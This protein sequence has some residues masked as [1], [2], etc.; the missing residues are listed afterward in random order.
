[1]MRRNSALLILILISTASLTWGQAAATNQPA[2]Q[3]GDAGITPNRVIGEVK[4][5]DKTA[6]QLVVKTDAGS[7]VTATLADTTQYMRVAPG[8]TSITNATKITFAELAEGDRVMAMGKV[9]EDKKT[10]PTRALVVMTKGDLAKKHEAERA[11]WR[12]RGI[13]GVV[14]ALNPTTKEITISSR[15]MGGMQSVIIPVSDKVELRRYAP[16]SIKF[17]DAKESSFAELQVGDQLRALGERAPD[18]TR[19]TPEKVVTGAF[20]TVVGT[21]T[22]VDAATGELKITEAE[23]KQALTIVVKQD[24]V[25]RRFPGEMGG[26]MMMSRPAGAGNAA[27]QPA[28][29]APQ[30]TS[31]GGGGPGGGPRRGGNFN[32][33]EMMESMPAIAIADLKPGEMI[34]V[35]STKGADPTRLTAIS[36]LS[37]AEPLLTMIAARQPQQAS[38]S[39]PNPAGGLGNSGIQFGIGLP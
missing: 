24:A 34:I 15:A 22:A 13:L 33:Q 30:S 7:L 11:E 2:P 36:L 5:I 1:M 38:G 10:V 16:D 6:K 32:I 17:G 9:S 25:L 18:G 8:E 3:G 31:P 20:R 37:G 39:A 35:S 23:K 19:F 4:A 26:G 21:V 14:S 12:R 27:G 28:A 29:G